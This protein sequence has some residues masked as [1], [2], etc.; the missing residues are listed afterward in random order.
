MGAGRIVGILARLKL[1]AAG[2]LR[3][4]RFAL[5]AGEEEVGHEAITD[6]LKS[7][8]SLEGK[9]F[10]LLARVRGIAVPDGGFVR[11]RDRWMTPTERDAKVLAD[12]IADAEKPARSTDARKREEGLAELRSLGKPAEAALVRAGIV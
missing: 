2:R 4:A 11:Y 1:D 3:L 10:A 5:E 7:D 8:G 12:R 6:A 9:A